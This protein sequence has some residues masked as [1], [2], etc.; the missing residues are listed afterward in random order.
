MIVVFAD[1]NSKQRTEGYQFTVKSLTDKK[2]VK[3]RQEIKAYN[4]HASTGRG[5]RLR[6]CARGR[7]GKNNPNRSKYPAHMYA[8]RHEDATRFDVYINNRY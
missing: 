8:V 7:L 6:V 1:G 4:K 5:D 2:L 3:L